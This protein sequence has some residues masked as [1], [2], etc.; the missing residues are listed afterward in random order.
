MTLLSFA[1]S[2]IARSSLNLSPA[3]SLKGRRINLSQDRQPLLELLRGQP[4]KM[5]NDFT[6]GR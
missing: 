6:K 2:S 1:A 4:G 3:R 5:R